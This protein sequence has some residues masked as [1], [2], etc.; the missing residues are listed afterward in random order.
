MQVLVPQP[1]YVRLV[2]ERLL[3]LV[4]L[5]VVLFLELGYQLILLLDEVFEVSVVEWLVFGF[6]SFG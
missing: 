5:P 2:F 1:E 3:Q 4:D 6:G